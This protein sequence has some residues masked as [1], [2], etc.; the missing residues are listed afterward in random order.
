MREM[1]SPTAAIAGW[2]CCM[3]SRSLRTDVSRAGTQGPLHRPYI[4]GSLRWAVDSG[5]EGRDG[6]VIDDPA[7]KLEVM[8]TDDEIKKRL[9][10]WKAPEPKR[11]GLS[12]RYVR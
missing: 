6:I 3:M 2:P 11:R 9:A 12:A 8:L 7:R 10:S 1:L 4:A 5:V